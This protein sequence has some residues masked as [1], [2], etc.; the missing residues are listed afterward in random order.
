M[1]RSEPTYM[2][3]VGHACC[4]VA[5]ILFAT[6]AWS[7]VRAATIPPADSTKACLDAPGT[8]DDWIDLQDGDI[9]RVVGFGTVVG[10]TPPIYY[11]LQAYLTQDQTPETETVEG[12]FIIGG[13]L[14]DGAGVVLLALVPGNASL[15][16][17]R[18]WSGGGAVITAPR[19]VRTKQGPIVVLK[20]SGD[21][22]SN[23]TYDA[24]FRY[25]GGKWTRVT[26]NWSGQI[27]LPKGVGQR[28][29]NSM[30]WPTLRA[31]GALWRQSDAECCPTGGSYIAQLRLDG[32]HLRLV[33][34][35]FSHEDLSFP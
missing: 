3:S 13:P 31:F 23:P 18:G 27:K 9:C 35:H 7:T 22:S 34:V 30:D 8:Q 12:D 25:V 6:L 4:V 11:Q 16:P 21:V 26:D 20:M 17:L 33:S 28:H 15:M 2:R 1:R 32:S 14:N 19:V 5:I 29:G 10:A 24:T